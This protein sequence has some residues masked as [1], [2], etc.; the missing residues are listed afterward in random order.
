MMK[1]FCFIILFISCSSLKLPELSSNEKENISLKGYREFAKADYIDHLKSYHNVYLQNIDQSEVLLSKTHRDYLASRV[2]KI[3]TAN[4]LFFKGQVEPEF[5][6][7]KSKVPFHFSLPGQK[8][9]FSTSLL[10]RYVKN[11]TMLYCLIV[12]ELVRSEKEIYSKNIIIPTG[13]L[14][15]E[16]LLSLLRLKTEDK[17]EIHK[18][19]YYLLKR[20]G[21][22]SDSY[23][24]WLQIKN[25]NS[26]DFAL[27][28][29]DVRSISREEALF[30]AFLI[31]NYLDPGR[32]SNYKGS[33]KIF[34]S[35]LR[36][37]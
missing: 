36:S 20:I 27:Q 19:S 15:T 25:R 21:L 31:D 3:I 7:V 33:S 12:Y 13:V 24:S 34:Y 23:L 22:E 11:E 32:R 14:D 28:L 17:V 5:H 37:I 2:K 9:F 16:R 6:I 18:W 4:E 26:L 1:Y 29:G 35:F 10:K 30:K 8:F